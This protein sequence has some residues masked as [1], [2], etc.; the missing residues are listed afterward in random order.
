MRARRNCGRRAHDGAADALLKIHK[1]ARGP[2]SLAE[3][4][5]RD[6]LSGPGQHERQGTVWQVLKTDLDAV[7]AELAGGQIGFENTEANR[8]CRYWTGTHK[9]IAAGEFESGIARE[10]VK[11]AL[12]GFARAL[13]ARLSVHVDSQKYSC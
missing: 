11:T 12:S 9:R 3:L 6:D 8:S 4:L 13:R 5:A 1:D 7:A 2:E 10:S